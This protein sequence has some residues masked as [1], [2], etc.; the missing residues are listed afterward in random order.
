MHT[1]D[2]SRNKSCFVRHVANPVFFDHT[3]SRSLYSR[4][5][6]KRKELNEEGWQ[7]FVM[8]CL[9]CVLLPALIF[10]GEPQN[11][12]ATKEQLSSSVRSTLEYTL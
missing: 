9:G 1:I 7:Q 12:A 8:L 2:H 10:P 3:N 6:P 4:A 5:E 11:H